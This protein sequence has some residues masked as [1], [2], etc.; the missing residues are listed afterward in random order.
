MKKILFIFYVLLC[1]YGYS[2]KNARNGAEFCPDSICR[3]LF[4]FADVTDDTLTFELPGW[5]EG[6]LPDY[7]EAFM[8]CNIDWRITSYITNFFHEAS[9]GSFNLIGD[10][11]PQ[12][13]TFSINDLQR[14]GFDN[15]VQKLD[16]ASS[17]G[18]VTRHGFS[19]SDFDIWKFPHGQINYTPKVK[20]RDNRLDILLIV[21]RHNSKYKKNPS[22]GSCGF[23]G[24]YNGITLGSLT[25]YNCSSM[26][27]HAEPDKVFRHEFSHTLIGGNNY[28]SGGSGTGDTCNFLSNI[29][30]YS[31]ISSYNSNL[32]SYNGWDRWWL[33]WK[34]PSKEHYISA[35]NVHGNEIAAD[36]EY[37]ESL[38]NNVFI[39]RNFAEYGDA[40]RIK[41]PYVKTLD[42]RVRNQYLWIENHQIKEGT[43]EHDVRKPKGIRFNIQIGND[44]LDGDFK[45]SRT[46]Y[47]VPLSAFGN[48]DFDYTALDTI[49]PNIH[50]FDAYTTDAFANPFTGYH[51]IMM[52]AWDVDVDGASIDDKIQSKEYITIHRIYKDSIS[53][54]GHLPVFGNR[55]DAFT[56]GASIGIGSNPPTTPLM[57]YRTSKRESGTEQTNNPANPATDD[58]RYIWLN[59]L[60]VDVLEEYSNGDVKVRVV[61]DDFDVDKDV[62]WCGPI[63][64]SEKIILKEYKNIILDYGLMPT[65]PNNPV[66]LFGRKIFADPTVFTCRDGSLFI[67]ESFSTVRVSNQSLLVIEDGAEYSVE[68]GALLDIQSSGTLLVKSGATLHIKG[69][70]RV[71]VRNGAYVCFE[72]GANIILDNVLSVINLHN[73]YYQG[74]N[75]VHQNIAAQCVDDP[76]PVFPISGDG[77]INVFSGNNYIQNR[78]YT[79]EA[80]ETG[81]KLQVGYQVTD[82]IEHGNVIIDDGADVVF[83]AEEEVNLEPGTEVR[84][85]GKLTVR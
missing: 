24:N 61:W 63:M 47:I 26:V 66:N 77:R 16:S 32:E 73:D 30:G 3:V 79:G 81:M 18:A 1:L 78:V 84:L 11:Y 44:R 25:G 82:E 4:V 12:L 41:L 39:L 68:D 5:T 38:G 65:R 6:H 71:E 51:P 43:V 29:G 50:W 74:V 85:G 46:N 22:G 9:F 35:V 21:W 62:R 31:M 57:T 80:Y 45:K 23:V 64:L 67:Q 36:L 42:E 27:C 20:T 59:G 52:P 19:L 69:S 28:H 54:C 58:N 70:G 53:A 75:S 83:D 37:G 7:A 60:R 13:M 76:L 10:Y 33:G 48:Y 56:A 55:F 2:Q 49:D 15:V 17:Y 72:E 34:H 14:Q 40:I 8:D